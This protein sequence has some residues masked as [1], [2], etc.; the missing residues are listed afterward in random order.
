M[1]QRT[2]IAIDVNDG[3]RGCLNRSCQPLRR[4]PGSINW[5]QP[6]VF[7]LTLNFVG[8][9]EPE[10]MARVHALV[11]ET[12]AEMQAF[13][14]RVCGLE[15]MPPKGRPMVI[16]ANVTEPTGRLL[17]LQERLTA[18][19]EGLGIPREDRSYRPHITIARIKFTTAS[20][21]I[22]A[23]VEALANEDFGTVQAREVGVYTSELRDSG[24]VYTSVVRAALAGSGG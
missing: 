2:F 9:I 13:D 14:F 18:G 7:H 21:D 22:R 4:H 10:Q 19:L 8:P 11:T 17:A 24:P 3:V 1:S 15:A 16:W 6:K 23:S 20:K 5:V 12:A